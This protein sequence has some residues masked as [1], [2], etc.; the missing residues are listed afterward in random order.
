MI[1]MDTPNSHLVAVARSLMLSETEENRIAT[2]IS[3]LQTRLNSWFGQEVIQHFRFGSSVRDTILPRKVDEGSDI[4]YMVVFNN[5]FQLKPATLL[6]KLRRFAN[7]YYSRSE[8]HQD[9]PTMVLELN[10]IKFEL[11]PAYQT[12]Y[13]SDFYNIPAPSSN[14]IDWLSTNPSEIKQKVDSANKLYNYQIKRLIRLL[15]YWNVRNNMVY[16]SF[17]LEEH[18]AGRLFYFCTSLEDYFYDAVAYLPTYTLPQ[19]K[20]DTVKQLQEKVAEIKA[21]YYNNGFKY[22]ALGELKKLLPIP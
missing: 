3:T 19:Y 15:K 13:W 9:H 22:S 14:Y 5:P 8:I 17:D 10:H 20:K 2:S 6:D 16:S 7:Y 18:I 1:M 12:S 4:D 11:V 21:N